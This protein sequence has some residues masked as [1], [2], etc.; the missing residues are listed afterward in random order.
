[1]LQSSYFPL[2]PRCPQL[3]Q[4]VTLGD[5]TVLPPSR[6]EKESAACAQFE[7]SIDGSFHGLVCSLSTLHYSFVTF[8]LIVGFAVALR[9]VLGYMCVRWDQIHDVLSN[10]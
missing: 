2:P 5:Y 7:P 8:N 10:A 6:I 3:L 4:S 1:M 9:V